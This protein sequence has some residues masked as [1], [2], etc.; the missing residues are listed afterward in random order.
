L[1]VIFLE[2]KSSRILTCFPLIFCGAS[3]KSSW[4][5]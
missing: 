4:C 3:E 5:C 1:M 2:N